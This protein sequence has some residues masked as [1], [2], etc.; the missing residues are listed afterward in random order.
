MAA[1]PERKWLGTDDKFARLRRIEELD[2]KVDHREITELFY[3]DFQSVMLVQGVSGFLFTFAAPRMSR[4]LKASG[5]VEHHTAKRYLDTSILTGAVMKSGLGPGDGRDAARRVN[6]MHRQ[7]DIH[8]EDFIAVGCDVPVMSLELAD[9]F[10]WRPVTQKERDALVIHYNL[11]ARAFG[12]HQPIPETVEGVR[13]FWEAYLDTEL[14]YEPQNKELS[15]ALL[16]FIPTLVPRAL[17]P[18]IN[19]IVTA[20]VDERVLRA[21]GLKAPSRRRKTISSMVLGAIGRSD[22]KPDRA[23]GDPSPSDALKKALYP[24]GWSIQTL[25]THLRAHAHDTKDDHEP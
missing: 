11:E 18:V 25:G 24:N 9:R 12:S 17:R 1:K 2:P 21:C 14:A 20:Q 8:P 4:I 3:T 7:Y 10:G 5:Q 13:A 19:S 15:E 23:D 22:P 6:A 16:A